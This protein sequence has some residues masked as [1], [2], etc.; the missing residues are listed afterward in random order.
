MWNFTVDVESVPE[1]SYVLV[2][3]RRRPP[4][5][6]IGVQHRPNCALFVT[7]VFLILKCSLELYVFRKKQ[8][9]CAVGGIISIR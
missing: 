9:R 1:V 8:G 2:L 5:R 6:N 4:L 3:H 7:C